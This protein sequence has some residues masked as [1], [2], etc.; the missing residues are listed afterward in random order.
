VLGL[1]ANIFEKSVDAQA[2]VY[3]KGHILNCFPNDRDAPK[4]TEPTIAN[5]RLITPYF[6]HYAFPP[7][8]ERGEMKFVL[9]QYRK[10]WG[11]ALQN[12][13]TTMAEVFD[14]NW[15]HCHQWSCCPTWQLS[16]YALGLHPRFDLGRNYFDFN[17]KAG[18]MRHASGRVPIA[19]STHAIE[20]LWERHGDMITWSMQCDEPVFLRFP[21]SGDLVKIHGSYKTKLA[22]DI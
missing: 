16:R 1:A 13:L 3:A 21:R 10:C 15:S 4:L 7:L 18:D 17:L 20:V 19:H 14:L 8:I 5:R 22:A 2:V 9:D 11:W 12:G 6:A